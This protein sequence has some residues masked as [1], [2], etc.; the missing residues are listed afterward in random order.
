MEL[1]ILT[2]KCAPKEV[3]VEYS[4]MPIKRAGPNKRAGGEKQLKQ[5]N[6]QGFLF[7]VMYCI[8]NEQGGEKSEKTVNE[9]ARLLGT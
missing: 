1:V 2:Q 4:Q 6:E 8:I 3:E 7:T 5:L 9:H